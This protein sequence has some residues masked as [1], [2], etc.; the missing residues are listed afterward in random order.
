MIAF[1]TDA[2]IMSSDD[3]AR[4]PRAQHARLHLQLVV[5]RLER[6][7]RRLERLRRPLH[8]RLD[9]KVEDASAAVALAAAPRKTRGRPSSA[10]RRA[11]T[12][13]A[14]ARA[15][16]APPRSRAPLVVSTATSARRP[17][18]GGRRGRRPRRR[19]TA[20]PR[21]P[22]AR[23]VDEERRAPTARRRRRRRPPRA[24]PSARGRWRRRPAPSPG[25]PRARRRTRALGVGL[26]VEQLGLQQHLLDQLVEPVPLLRR[27][28]R[29]LCVSP[30]KS[31]RTTSCS[32][33]PCL[34]TDGSAPSLSDLVDRDD[35]R[36][37]ACLRRADRLDRLLLDA[38]VGGDDEDDD[39]G[40][41]RAARAH[42]VERRVPR[43]VDE[44][45]LLRVAASSSPSF[46]QSIWYAPMCCVMPP[47]S[48]PATSAARSASRSDVLPWS[49][50]PTIVTT[51]GGSRLAASSS[52]SMTPAADSANSSSSPSSASRVTSAPNPSAISAARSG[53]IDCVI[54]ARTPFFIRSLTTSAAPT[55]SAVASSPTVIGP[56]IAPAPAPSPR[57]AGSSSSPSSPSSP[58]APAPPSAAT[59]AG[60]YS[61]S[62]NP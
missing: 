53:S 62:S 29:R 52:S 9:D 39:V 60:V 38:V 2:S 45:E 14:R 15:A 28:R 35:E 32:R 25:A 43:R 40:D 56:V 42:L 33:R 54:D 44:R 59:R 13:G 4:R 16:G 41:V 48:P 22:L 19:A 23:L 46:F 5:G 58:G 3:R 37:P 50:W 61:L 31:S 1:D 20:P 34:T 47:A 18:R 8:V 10:R 12:R 49:T 30:P 21:R 55:S 17:R 51:G 6:L 36:H 7:D 27:H 11:T 57:P 26:E 24:S